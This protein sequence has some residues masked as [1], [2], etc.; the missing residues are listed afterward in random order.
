MNNPPSLRF[1][2]KAGVEVVL[3][4]VVDHRSAVES[5]GRGPV[6]PPGGPTAAADPALPAI[7]PGMDD[8]WRGSSRIG[9]GAETSCAS[10]AERASSEIDA[11]RYPHFPAKARAVGKHLPARRT[12]DH[13]T[14]IKA[15]NIGHGGG[16][17]QPGCVC[18]VSQLFGAG[19][20]TTVGRGAWGVGRDRATLARRAYC[21]GPLQTRGRNCDVG[22]ITPDLGPWR[23]PTRTRLQRVSSAGGLARRG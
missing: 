5:A 18:R 13:H 14:P 8:V 19:W 22:A 4:G 6:G 10:S 11:T 1:C 23:T 15:A 2:K 7:G 12:G 21:A 9:A 20:L 3:A 17:C 16:G